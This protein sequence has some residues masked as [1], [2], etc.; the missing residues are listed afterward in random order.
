MRYDLN[1]FSYEITIKKVPVLSL[2]QRLLLFFLLLPRKTGT[3]RIAGYLA[4]H[5]ARLF[6]ATHAPG[7]AGK[8]KYKTIG[9]IFMKTKQF[10][11]KLSLNKETVVHL[12]QDEMTRAQGGKETFMIRLCASLVETCNSSTCYGTGMLYTCDCGSLPISFLPC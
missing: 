12:S 5:R 9:E 11:K 6:N 1:C 10:S 4:H 3:E 8:N 2:V 7:C